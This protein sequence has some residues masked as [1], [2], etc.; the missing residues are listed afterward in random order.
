[1]NRQEKLQDALEWVEMLQENYSGQE[2]TQDLAE[3]LGV[4]A[5]AIKSL[6]QQ[7]SEDCISRAEV[8]KILGNEVFELT[9]LH[10]VNPEDNPKA[11]AMAYGVNW[12]LNTLMELPSVKPTNGDIKEA[13]IKG[14]DYGVKD[15][16]KSKTQPCDDC[17]SRQA[18]RQEL[19]EHHDFYVNAYG[20]FKDMPF[21]EKARVDEII[22]CIAMVVN[23]PSVTPQKPKGKWIYWTDDYK[24]YCT[25]SECGYGEEGEVL[26]KDKTPYCPYCGAKLSGGGE[27]E[28]GD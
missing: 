23:E 1:M 5:E 12:S 4:A 15:W 16:F 9:K 28:V 13:Y 11:D 10:T 14:Y 2:E 21:N 3:A 18:L 22:N 19:Q 8:R 27:D 26:L 20:S 24:D 25:C 17:I 7:P 6:E